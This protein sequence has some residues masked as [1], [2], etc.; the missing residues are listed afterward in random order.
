MSHHCHRL[1][2]LVIAALI[3]GGAPSG[4]AGDAGLALGP[5]LILVRDVP[6]GRSFTLHEAAK[7]RFRLT[8]NSDQAGDFEVVCSVPTD[9]GM[10]AHEIGYEA[11]P[12]PSWFTLDKR[13]ITLAPGAHEEIDLRVDIPDRPELFNRHWMLYIDAGRVAHAG[14]GATLRLRARVMLETRVRE[15]IGAALE[16]MGALGIDPGTVAMRRVDGAWEGQARLRNNTTQPAVY[17]LLRMDQAI[18]DDQAD[19]RARYFDH[20]AM[21]TRMPLGRPAEESLTLA[22][23]EE[24][25]L[26]FTAAVDPAAST[27][28]PIEEVVFIARR[29]PAQADPKLCRELAG[30]LYDHAGLVRLR[31]AAPAPTPATGAAPAP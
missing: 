8:N 10:R 24:R 19:K 9:G 28:A 25:V 31:F 3:I 18:P 27:T 16:H 30:R 6:P 14:I 21:A 12:D 15:G 26:R 22:P 7:V 2:P 5:A 1:L 20:A 23:G 29:A 13:V 17:D 4:T 11:P